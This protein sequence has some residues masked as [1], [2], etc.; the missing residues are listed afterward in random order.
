MADRVK[1]QKGKFK[2]LEFN[3]SKR[4]PGIN[5]KD[6][7]RIN[8][9]EVGTTSWD[10]RLSLEFT[11]ESPAV[12]HVTI[13]PIEPGDSIPTI[14]LCGNST[15]VDQ[16]NEPWASWG[17]LITAYLDNGICVSN[18]AESG[19]R[20]DSF[21]A[22]KRLDK[23][24]SMSRPGD[25][26]FIEFGH[27]DQKQKTPGSGA[28]YNFSTALKTFIDRARKAGLNPV[29][30]TPTARRHFGADGHILDTHGE[31]PDAMRAVAERENVPLIELNPMTKTLYESLGVEGSKKAFVHYPAGTFPGQDKAMEDNTHFNP[32]G[33]SQ[34]AKCVVEGI[35]KN[36]PELAG[37][38][39]LPE[40][41][42]P[43]HPDNPAEFIWIRAPFYDNVKPYGN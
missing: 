43:S 16:V 35:R 23:V 32:Y 5:L 12:R 25:W 15:V 17:Q 30:I 4:S 9:R 13:E 22:S 36:I 39:T 31:Y 18:H 29:F 37:H 11:G 2:T 20:A 21:L 7:V 1:T 3:V 34:V 24:L 6:S 33:A 40:D 10:D 26:I 38:I 14:F 42:D 28:W 8:P 19:Q 41:Y 27:N